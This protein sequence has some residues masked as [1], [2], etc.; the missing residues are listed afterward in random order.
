MSRREPTPAFPTPVYFKRIYTRIGFLIKNHIC[1]FY[2]SRDKLGTTDN[3]Y[4]HGVD[5]I[6]KKTSLPNMN[7]NNY[8]KSN[9]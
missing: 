8:I 4:L 7:K 3:Q 2:V 1:L 5:M 6:E 9:C